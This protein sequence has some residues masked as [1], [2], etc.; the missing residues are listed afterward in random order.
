VLQ[1]LMFPK[2]YCAPLQNHQERN[3]SLITIEHLRWKVFVDSIQVDPVDAEYLL[4][5]GRFRRELS[6]R[7]ALPI[8]PLHPQAL[9]KLP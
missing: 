8:A 1:Q 3:R 9:V 4:P 5:L 7:V 2:N 6:F